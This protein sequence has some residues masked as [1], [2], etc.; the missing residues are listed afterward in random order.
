[1]LL[2]LGLD[3]ELLV[4]AAVALG[5]VAPSDLAASQ[6]LGGGPVRAARVLDNLQMRS[7]SRAHLDTTMNA[8]KVT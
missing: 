8:G 6:I 1:M 2:S 7:Q 5:P 4:V 3:L